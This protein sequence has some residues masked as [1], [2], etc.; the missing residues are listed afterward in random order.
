MFEV[1]TT[2]INADFDAM[3]SMLAARKLYPEAVLVFPGSQERNL[4]E[5]LL[6][7][8]YYLFETERVRRIDLNAVERLILVDTR[9]RSRIGKFAQIINRPNVDIH[10][11][12]HHPPSDEDI[13]GNLEIVEE[14][15]ATM[16]I[17][18]RLLREKG[19]SIT[20][21]EATVMALGIYEDTGS[22]SFISTREKDFEAAAYLLSQGAN[23]NVVSDMMTR[24]LTAEQISL[25]NELIESATHYNIHGVDLVIAKASVNKFVGDFAVLV[26]KL[27]DMENLDVLIAL[28]RMDDRIYLVARSRVEE[29]NVGDVAVAFG[30]GGHAVAA[31]ATIRD[32]T[33]Y[34]VEEKL[35]KILQEKITPKHHAVDLMSAPVK[36]VGPQATLR[37]VEEVL[38]RYSI[39]A[40]PVIEED[41]LVGLISRLVVEKAV[42]HGLKD[43]P[44]REYMT[45]EFSI[46]NPE[47]PYSTV[48]ALIIEHNQRFLPVIDGD[49]VVGVI[50]RG[51]LLRDLQLDRSKFPEERSE[52][53]PEP[54]YPRP[55][56]L[57]R[58]MEERFP[59]WVVQLLRGAGSLAEEMGF[60]VYLVGG[61][62]RD[63]L[64]RIDNLDLDLVVEGE[65][66]AF[67]QELGRREGC[68]V[69]S[70]LKFNTA[71]V[72]LPHR[73]E[74]DVATAR[75]EYYDYPGALPK[76]EYGSIKR[77][78]ARRDFTMN[79]L[80]L[81]LNPGHFGKVMDFFGGQRDI[82]ERV[83][84]VLH[85]LS[86]VEDPTRIFRAIRFEQR[87]GFQ[88]VK[89]TMHL[90]EN[91]VKL[92]FFDRMAGDR[93]FKELQYM[94]NEHHAEECVRRMAELDVLRFIHTSIT[95][96]DSMR[97]ML[98]RIMEVLN[99]FDLLFLD[100]PY[101][102]SLV[103]FYALIDPL[104]DSELEELCQ[105]LG[106]HYGKSRAFIEDRRELIQA[107]RRIYS[108]DQPSNSQ[109][110]RL[111]RRFSLEMLFFAMARTRHKSTQ[112]AI[113]RFI[114]HL[115]RTHTLLRGKDLIKLGLPQGPIIGKALETLLD[116]RLDGL[117]KTRVEEEA[118]IEENFIHTHMELKNR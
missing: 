86:F 101:E 6:H 98:G 22:F 41:K 72:F 114:T 15:G 87:F 63:L 115:R 112:I 48:L 97:E 36:F 109:I 57:S 111:L 3:A 75:M 35:L 5:F 82:K 95:Y 102:R 14:V 18:A 27:K 103:Y 90:V 78:M 59:P 38:N 71:T 77:D 53:D 105:R 68:K 7:S 47:T 117:V 11:Y 17:M 65:G 32:L 113:S 13:N 16:T 43:L 31:S 66:I 24:E 42:F 67:A 34:Q 73:V 52:D 54:R 49:R 30:G 74:L 92:N 99:W 61:A 20:P 8:T 79:T 2:H 28:A 40:L 118:F 23:L 91:A 4:K 81:S 107:I 76:V 51:D 94:L 39:N 26:H 56:N 89:H 80:A 96:N 37:E 108:L 116:A 104:E 58:L 62:V 64:L 60:K 45:R 46:V 21:D 25:L 12:D 10:I 1:I 85:N 110:N 93:L 33:L 100:E 44:V 88:M 84:R 69:S 29:V 70:H 55:K 50:T 9:Q 83:I 19:I 106:I